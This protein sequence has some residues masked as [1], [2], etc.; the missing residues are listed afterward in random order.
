MSEP[1]TGSLF[2]DIMRQRQW[3]HGE[4]RGDF[5]DDVL[6]TLPSPGFSGAVPQA[7][8]CSYCGRSFKSVD[9]GKN[10]QGCGAGLG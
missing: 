4:L 9:I 10:C 8:K 2:K 7:I 1:L 6:A 5:I 3:E